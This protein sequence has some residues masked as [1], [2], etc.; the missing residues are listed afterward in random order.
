MSTLMASKSRLGRNSDKQYSR[1]T[2]EVTADLNSTFSD[3]PD[4]DFTTEIGPF[5]LEIVG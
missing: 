4:T 2:G 3:K 1:F 5:W